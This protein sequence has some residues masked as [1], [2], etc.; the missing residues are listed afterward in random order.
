MSKL[1]RDTPRRSIVSSASATWINSSVSGA[2][3][4]YC[5]DREHDHFS[6]RSEHLPPANEG[7]IDADVLEPVQIAGERI[8]SEHDH[9]RD[10]AGLQRSV[11]VLVPGQAMAALRRHP[12]RLLPG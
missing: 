12:Q 9:V 6:G 1:M 4:S 8:F 3:P 7:S 5:Q 2:G 10:L 11:S